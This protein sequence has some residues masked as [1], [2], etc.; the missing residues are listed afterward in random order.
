MPLRSTPLAAYFAAAVV[1]TGCEPPTAAVREDRLPI[2]E[3]TEGRGRAAREGSTVRISYRA[4]L[5]DGSELLRDRDYRFEV[6]AGTV[7]LGVDE[8]VRGMRPG[9]TRTVR[10]PPHKHWGSAG[11][12]DGEVPPDTTLTFH[13]E[14]LGVR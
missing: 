1:L 9:G 3:E 13:I 10:V 2:I 8:A 7:I 4:T 5:E 6:G 14:M 11:Y 12:G